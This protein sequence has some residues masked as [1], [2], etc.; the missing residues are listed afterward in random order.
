MDLG[1]QKENEEQQ[2]G[3]C[4]VARIFFSPF[5]IHWMLSTHRFQFCTW[6]LDAELVTKND[7]TQS[8]Q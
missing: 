8:M 2:N 7:L 4:I 1:I 5:L 6:L 3:F